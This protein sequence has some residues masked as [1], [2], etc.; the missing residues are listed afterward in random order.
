MWVPNF[1]S[2]LGLAAQ[3]PFQPPLPSHPFGAMV[4]NSTN[5]FAFKEGP[6]ILSPRELIELERP[7][8]GVANPTGDLLLVSVSKYSFE[9]KKCV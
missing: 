1:S 4:V 5:D 6:N 8:N 7:G 3:V 2:L 9:K